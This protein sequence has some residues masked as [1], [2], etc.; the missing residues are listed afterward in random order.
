MTC[1]AGGPYSD[2]DLGYL[3]ALGQTGIEMVAPIALG[4]YLDRQFGWAPWGVVV[5]AVLGLAGGL[6]HMLW[7]IKRHEE[8][9]SQRPPDGK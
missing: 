8:R 3:F 9:R 7:M 4:A 6:T 5:G 1:V 2:R